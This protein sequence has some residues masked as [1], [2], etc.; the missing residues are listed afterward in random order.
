MPRPDRIES[1]FLRL[2]NASP[3]NPVD[4]PLEVLDARDNKTLSLALEVA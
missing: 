3:T 2:L 4:Y 1:A